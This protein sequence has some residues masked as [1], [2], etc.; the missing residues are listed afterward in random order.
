MPGIIVS[1]T[2]CL[3]LLDKIGRIELLK[4][5]FGKITITGII[6]DEFGKTIPGFIETE[7]PKDKTYQKILESFLDPGEASAIALALE[8][9]ECLLILDDAKG[10]CEARQLN[11]KFTGTLGILI[12]AKEKGLIDS[13]STVIDEIKKTDFRISEELLDEAKKKCGE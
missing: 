1:D 11:L 2:S 3:I 13:I 8:K 5:L 7:N 9:Q 10:R 4:L 12:V 6:A